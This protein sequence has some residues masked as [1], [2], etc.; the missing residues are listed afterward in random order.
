MLD[1][2]VF[3]HEFFLWVSLCINVLGGHFLLLKFSFFWF[4]LP[5]PS[6]FLWSVA[7]PFGRHAIDTL[8]IGKSTG[9]EG[10]RNVLQ[11]TKI[12]L[13]SVKEAIKEQST[14]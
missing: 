5:P 7:V 13:H 9:N 10:I 1:L 14:H 12:S 8:T 3:M 2:S 4:S 6:L 11:S